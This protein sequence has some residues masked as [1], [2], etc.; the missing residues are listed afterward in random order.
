MHG[1]RPQIEDIT[2][3]LLH[4]LQARDAFDF[5]ADFAGPLPCLVI[6]AML[7]VPRE[8]L[9]LVKRLSDDI[10]LFIGSS[11][12]TSEKYDTAQTATHEMAA[13]FRAMI[14]DRQARPQHDLLS[15]LTHLRDGDDRLSEDE[16]IALCIL[17]LFAGHETTTN[18]LANG[19]AALMRFPDQM[20]RWRADPVITSSAIEELLRYDGPSG[21]IVRIVRG[22]TSLHGKT[23]HD[24]D[25]VFLMM[26]AA[27]R[28]PDAF[29]DPDQLDLTR[30]G[31]PHLAFG[32]GTHICL[33][34]P[35]ARTEGQVALPAVLN[36]FAHIEPAA[37][38]A[39]AWINSLVFRGMHTLPVRVRPA[40]V[41]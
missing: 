10:A 2:R 21:A 24:G 38:A 35:L 29:A 14:V 22:E 36:A 20:A 31:R 11:R 12:T 27:N 26:H 15:E 32:F 34:F 16:L 1:M 5:I 30:D 41:P 17:L 13:Y 7:G 23:L 19:M 37:D 18:H 33:G 6:M 3:G 39:P 8:D 25:R 9:A 28:D 40:C 4:N